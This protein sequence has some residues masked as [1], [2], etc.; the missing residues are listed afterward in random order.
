MNEAFEYASVASKTYQHVYAQDNPLIIKAMW[1]ELSIAYA[2]KYSLTEELAADLFYALA[3]RD[4]ILSIGGDI[5]T[6]ERHVE[7]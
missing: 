3:K 1:Q 2:T 6:Y 7:K 4:Y 5:Q